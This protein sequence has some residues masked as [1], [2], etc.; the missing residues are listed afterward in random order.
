MSAIK[1]IQIVRSANELHFIHLFYDHVSSC[2]LCLSDASLNHLYFIT[3]CFHKAT[4]SYSNRHGSE[5]VLNVLNIAID[6]MRLSRL[7]YPK[8]AAKTC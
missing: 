6:P 3:K 1:K 7:M 4:C 2:M 8:V 5:I